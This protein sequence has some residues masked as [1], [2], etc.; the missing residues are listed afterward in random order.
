MICILLPSTYFAWKNIPGLASI[1][2]ATALLIPLELISH[3]AELSSLSKDG[4]S[5]RRQTSK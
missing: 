3:S 1:S 5:I 4:D 2:T